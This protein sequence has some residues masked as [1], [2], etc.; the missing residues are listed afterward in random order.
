M[1]RR[2]ASVVAPAALLG[3]LAF[4]LA[5]ADPDEAW[6]HRAE[7]PA[8]VHPLLVLL[9]DTSAAAARTTLAMSR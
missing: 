9:M 6:L 5:L 8:E 3:S 7:L 1:I 2:R 4:T